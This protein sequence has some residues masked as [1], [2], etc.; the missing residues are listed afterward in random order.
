MASS[1]LVGLRDN[2]RSEFN[3]SR[4]ENDERRHDTVIMLSQDADFSHHEG[5]L[6]SLR[7]CLDLGR[8]RRLGR[9]DASRDLRLRCSSA[10]SHLSTRESPPLA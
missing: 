9:A 4:K 10:P 7:H 6:L 5:C 1:S 3:G 8:Q 2:R